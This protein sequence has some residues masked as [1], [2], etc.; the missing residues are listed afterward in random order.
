[1]A[2]HIASSGTTRALK[3]QEWRETAGRS[4]IS[5][6]KNRVLRRYQ[7]EASSTDI[8]RRQGSEAGPCES[9]TGPMSLWGKGTTFCPI[10][11]FVGWMGGNI[12]L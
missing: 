12:L 5:M 4:S 2:Q 3:V 11:C 10:R 1:M 9:M 7:G 8:A 6:M